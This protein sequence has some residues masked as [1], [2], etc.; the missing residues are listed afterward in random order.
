MEIKDTHTKITCPHCFGEYM[1]RKGVDT[2]PQIKIHLECEECTATSILEILQEGDDL[3][4][5]WN[6]DKIKEN[7]LGIHNPYSLLDK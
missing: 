5:G 4:I 7:E 2:N 6:K 1:K 3:E